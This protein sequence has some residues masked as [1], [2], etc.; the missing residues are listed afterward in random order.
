M[1]A[2]GGKSATSEALI[3]RDEVGGGSNCSDDTDALCIVCFERPR[4]AKLK[5]G[6]TEFCRACARRCATCPLCRAPTG[7]GANA[8]DA[9]SGRCSALVQR[10]C[11]RSDLWATLATWPWR[12]GC[13]VC[14]LATVSVLSLCY[15]SIYAVLRAAGVD[16]AC[17]GLFP[18]TETKHSCR[19]L[20]GSL[21]GSCEGGVC[22]LAPAY[23]LS[24]CA[25][26]S[27]CGTYVRDADAMCGGAPLYEKN[28]DSSADVLIRAGQEGQKESSWC[29]TDRQSG[30]CGTGVAT[31]GCFVSSGNSELERGP[32]GADYQPWLFGVGPGFSVVPSSGSDLCQGV[33][34]PAA[35][36]ACVV[37]GRWLADPKRWA[38]GADT[39]CRC[40]GNFVSASQGGGAGGGGSSSLSCRSCGAH[41]TS[42]D[43]LRCDCRDGYVGEFCASTLPEGYSPRYE[44]SGCAEG[45]HA[46]SSSSL[47][48]AA[49]SSCGN[50]SRLAQTCDGAPTYLQLCP[51]HGTG[52]SSPTQ[53]QCADG[54]SRRALWR[55]GDQRTPPSPVTTGQVWRVTSAARLNDCNPFWKEGTYLLSTE[56]RVN[57]SHGAGQSSC[58]APTG[59]GYTPWSEIQAGG[60]G[61]ANSSRFR[62]RALP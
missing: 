59:L 58:G 22:L 16:V 57:G 15:F 38:P 49:A 48:D 37:A 12:R 43:G 4:G 21:Y 7:N 52:R 5:C 26:A 47:S 53:L 33:E 50:Y 56:Y 30:L 60:G 23:V 19:E 8:A 29:V 13:A 54:S 24:D 34:C 17:A 27:K 41:G 39:G 18:G 3:P 51:D 46:G 35:H 2:S 62:V 36:S 28:G 9:A 44:L 61:F 32:D 10:C 40:V 45:S 11:P 31:P 20:Y 55:W 1:G 6:H 14:F 42:R 25:D